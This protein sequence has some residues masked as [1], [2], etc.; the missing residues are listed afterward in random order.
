MN[1]LIYDTNLWD[2]KLS[3]DQ[4]YFG[5]CV[6]VL[7]RECAALSDLT[8]AEML[9]FLNIVRKYETLFKVKYGATMFN[10][11]CLMNNA[12]KNNPPEPQMHWHCRPRYKETVVFEGVEF[13]DPNFAHHYER[14]TE[15]NLDDKTREKLLDQLRSYLNT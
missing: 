13:K 15:S 11:T 12:Y 5:R 2:I 9:D 8:E 4:T 7:K 1:Q 14:G 3:E 6:V 10:W